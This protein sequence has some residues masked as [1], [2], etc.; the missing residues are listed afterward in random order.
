MMNN[1][2]QH[3]IKIANNLD[4]NG[5]FKIADQI[6]N[7]IKIAA[8]PDTKDT[9]KQPDN[10]A[11]WAGEDKLKEWNEKFQPNMH[12]DQ[13]DVMHD[14]KATW[15]QKANREFLNS[16]TYVHYGRAEKLDPRMKMS[17]LELSCIAYK[18]P[19]YK[20]LWVGNAGIMLKGHV[21]LAANHD[22]QTNQNVFA[23]RQRT[24]RWTDRLPLIVDEKDFI[25]DGEFNEFILVNW[26]PIAIVKSYKN[27][28]AKDMDQ[29][30]SAEN[31]AAKHNLPL[32]DENG[33]QIN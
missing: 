21:T 11:E 26:T 1:K 27:E 31:L 12:E 30:M 19:P 16:L 8:L 29:I 23:P 32:L 7:Q 24:M 18:K 2:I 15:N 6:T 14:I 9:T 13:R 5:L 10:T 28:S 3:L 4:K 20:N 22:L 33:N 25:E 17:N